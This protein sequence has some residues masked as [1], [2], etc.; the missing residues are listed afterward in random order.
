MIFLSKRWFSVSML[1]FGGVWKMFLATP[2][3][4]LRRVR[5]VF[6]FK[7]RKKIGTWN[8]RW[9]NIPSL[10]LTFSPLKIDTWK[11]VSFFGM[12]SFKGATLLVSA[13]ASQT[14][15]GWNSSSLLLSETFTLDD[16]LKKPRT[17]II[18]GHPI[19]QKRNEKNGTQKD[20]SL[21]NSPKT[22]FVWGTHPKNLPTQKKQAKSQ[23]RPSDQQLLPCA[24]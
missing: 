24:W 19:H 5:F 1:I 4:I 10:K 20:S 7:H 12:P 21:T 23:V 18:I 15:S 13:R 22:P 8:V 11:T 16:S 2:V 9:R 17:K 6:L 3:P 14:P